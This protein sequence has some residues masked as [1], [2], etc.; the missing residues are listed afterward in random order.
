M[1]TD[2]GPPPD[3]PLGTLIHH[4]GS[5]TG[6]AEVVELLFVDGKPKHGGPRWR[7]LVRFPQNRASEIGPKGRIVVQHVDVASVRVVAHQQDSL[8]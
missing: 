4:R 8:F 6:Q 3:L 2:P 5:L 1:A 7:V